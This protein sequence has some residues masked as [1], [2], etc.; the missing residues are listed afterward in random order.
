[1]SKNATRQM[2]LSVFACGIGHY[3]IAGWRH[4]EGYPDLSTNIW[5]WVELVKKAEDAKFDFLFVPDVAGASFF[6]TPDIFERSPLSDRIEPMTL[7]SAL[8]MV[9]KHLGLV[10]T[11]ATSYKP[12]YDVAR[13]MASLDLISGGRSGWNI[14][15]GTD[16]LDAAQ[17]GDDGFGQR[18]E[19]YARGE[20]FADVVVA[21]WESVQQGAFPRDRASGVYANLEK[22]HTIDHKGKYYS[23]KGPL[24]IDRSP[25][26]RPILV[27]AGQS[28]EGRTFAARV[29][30][31]I[32]TAWSEFEMGRKFYTDMKSRAAAMNRNPDCLK[33][34]PG[35]RI[36]VGKTESE[37]N[38][39]EKQLDS[40][41]DLKLA[42]GKLVMGLSDST[43][44]IDLSKYPLDEPFPDLSK[45][46][47][48]GPLSGRSA[49]HLEMARKHNLT[50]REVLIRSSNSNMHFTVKGTPTQVVDQ[51]EHWFKDGA[52][53]GFNI[54]S[55]YMPGSL[56]DVIT[57]VLP[58]LRRRGLFRTEYEG[59]TLRE[60]LGISL[61]PIP[62]RSLQMQKQSA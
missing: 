13:Q 4:P 30:E 40:L 32:F 16:S 43:R 45:D 26:G 15:T 54:L 56:D 14:V 49:N 36:I 46:P 53:D 47:A 52:A 5:R 35:V 62:A 21:L 22:I 23:V 57:F 1:M 59:R 8:A 9:T 60:N 6:D 25:Q 29:A 17:Y 37:A 7:L 61:D 39:K 19:R 44:G 33:V 12:P 55:G 58:E 34:M 31:V 20:E 28:E 38:E 2:K 18:N 3:H 51:L 41:I 24:S 27:Q 11:M 50:L 10:S 42:M 48:V